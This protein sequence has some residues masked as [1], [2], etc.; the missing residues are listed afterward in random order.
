[1][2]IKPAQFFAR[3]NSEQKV[4][5]Q[6]RHKM[7]ITRRHTA[8]LHVVQEPTQPPMGVT[9]ASDWLKHKFVN[10]SEL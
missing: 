10:Q 5:R 2:I 3:L 4:R 1:M 9:F 6:S 8:Q 7:Q